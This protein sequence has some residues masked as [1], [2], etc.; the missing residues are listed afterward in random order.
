MY[1]IIRSMELTSKYH[2]YYHNNVILKTIFMDDETQTN[3]GCVTQAWCSSVTVHY[4]YY[5]GQSKSC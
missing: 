1:N 4:V 5:S 3:N 2:N